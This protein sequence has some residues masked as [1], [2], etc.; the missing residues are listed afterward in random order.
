MSSV[1]IRVATKHW[2]ASRR[3][4][5]MI[6]IFSATVAGSPF[7]LAL[8][9]KAAGCY[10]RQQPL[11]KP[12]ADFAVQP[13][14][15]LAPRHCTICA[16]AVGVASPSSRGTRLRAGRPYHMRVYLDGSNDSS[17]A[18]RAG[19]RGRPAWWRT[20]EPGHLE[21]VVLHVGT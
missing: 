3:T 6:A 19:V 11:G 8:R 4:V 2:W 20:E 7:L 10:H 17:G 13:D 12:T 21:P 1:R 16:A 14:T 18:A 5:S 15:A 9:G